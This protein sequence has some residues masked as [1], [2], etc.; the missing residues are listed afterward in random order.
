M[1]HRY[2]DFR[3]FVVCG[4][5]FDF[6]RILLRVRCLRRE[7]GSAFGA[8]STQTVPVWQS[9]CSNTKN[10]SSHVIVDGIVVSGGFM[11]AGWITYGFWTTH[12]EESWSWRI[13]G[14]FIG[15][16]ALMVL[17]GVYLFPESPR[18]LV[19][20]G[21]T[22][23]AA[24]I[25][26]D[27][28]KTSVDSEVVQRDLSAV[29]RANEASKHTKWTGLFSYRENKMLWRLFLT[30]TVQFYTQMN[31]AG[32][33]TAY[34][35]QLF[36][37]IGLGPD[38]A[39]IIAG[40]SLTFKLIMCCIPY[41]VIERFGRRMLFMVSGAGMAICMFVL[42]ICGSQTTP[43]H[44]APAYVAIVF[45]FL[46]LIFLPL[47]YLGVNF[48]YCQEVIS[49]RYRAPAGGISTAVLW[50]TQFVLALTTPLGLQ[51][52]SWRYYLIWGCVSATIVPAVYFWY[53]E[54]TGLSME[55]LEDIWAVPGGVTSAVR[56][57]KRLRS[58][59]ESKAFESGTATPVVVEEKIDT[60]YVEKA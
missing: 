4:A 14:I 32:I 12:S 37:T 21:R 27:I 28:H 41:F 36:S 8:D 22:E 40:V 1:G 51:V 30:V 56:E 47:A 55:E 11:L 26:A 2:D 53:P 19:M 25:F 49:T 42:A 23:E 45:V 54:T 15:I 17:S 46:F 20:K 29:I 13:P 44:L 34:S 59:K 38:L 52:L 10:R 18:W 60:D 3:K 24:L 48:L 9:E 50:L 5:G 43:T 39:H 33:I 7:V 35:S 58:H 6:F 57:A 31:G 16:F